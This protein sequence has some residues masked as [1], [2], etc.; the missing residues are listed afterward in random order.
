MSRFGWKRYRHFAGHCDGG[1]DVVV[2]LGGRG[3]GAGRHDNL[4]QLD[5][6]QSLR[7]LPVDLPR[8]LLAAAAEALV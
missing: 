3:R 8:A 7:Y 1:V 6:W 4:L 2:E 5:Q